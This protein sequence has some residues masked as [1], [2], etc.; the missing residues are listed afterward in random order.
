ML[1]KP[2]RFRRLDLSLTNSADTVVC[3]APTGISSAIAQWPCSHG[4]VTQ[5]PA[6]LQSLVSDGHGRSIPCPVHFADSEENHR[7]SCDDT[8]MA[9][10]GR[11]TVKS[12]KKSSSPSVR[13]ENESN[14][15]SL[16]DSKR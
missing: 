1:K 4:R 7:F 5:T 9:D 2:A 6:L 10:A 3:L 11:M 16:S 8:A 14:S 12:L 15:E 13:M